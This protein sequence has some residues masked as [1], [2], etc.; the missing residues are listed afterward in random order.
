[1]TDPIEVR[2]IAFDSIE[3]QQAVRLRT[4]VLRKPL[5]LGFSP[6]ELARENTSFHFAAFENGALVGCLILAPVSQ[7][8]LKMRQV[9]VAPERQGLGIGGRLVQTAEAFASARGYEW[10][11]LSARDGAVQFYLTRGYKLIGEPYIEVT[12]LHRAMQKRLAPQRDIKHRRRRVSS[13]S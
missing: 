12:I 5:G 9:A 3:Y 10:L 7:S 13:S 4:A 11:R 8:E 2:Q 6:E 1:M